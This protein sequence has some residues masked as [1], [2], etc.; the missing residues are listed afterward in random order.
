MLVATISMF[1]TASIG[2]TH[3]EAVKCGDMKW[4]DK[5]HDD[6]SPSGNK[7]KHAAYSENLCELAK[8]IDHSIYANHDSVDWKKFKTSPAFEQATDEQQE[9]LTASHKNGNGMNGLGG[10]EILDCATGKGYKE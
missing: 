8:G 1:L 3:I 6:N 4:G 7:F 2:N 9:C 5:D 10:Y